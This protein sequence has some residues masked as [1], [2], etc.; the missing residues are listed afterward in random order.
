MIKQKLQNKLKFKRHSG[1]ALLVALLLVA[2]IGAIILTVSRT[3]IIKLRI[4]TDLNQAHVAYYAAEAGIEEGLLAYRAD[5]NI[6]IPYNQSAGDDEPSAPSTKYRTVVLDD[7]VSGGIISPT[8]NKPASD[9][10]YYQLKIYY[11]KDVFNSKF[12]KDEIRGFAINRSTAITMKW[13][14]E[15]SNGDP[16]PGAIG[17]VEYTTLGVNN[18]MIKQTNPSRISDSDQAYSNNGNKI[19]PGIDGLLQIRFVMPRSANQVFSDMQFNDLRLNIELK[20]SSG[21]IDSGKTY[22]ESI[23][24][25]GEV[26]RK[27]VAEVNR[28]SGALINIFDFTLYANENIQ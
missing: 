14:I 25:F 16:A 27:L 10:A 28:K 23:G 17:Y 15:Y 8:T 7:I 6:Q 20:S 4:T 22:I 11:K 26:K 2:T 13:N 21:L 12:V 3:S 18:E 1:S 19:I 24:V 5:K 9:K